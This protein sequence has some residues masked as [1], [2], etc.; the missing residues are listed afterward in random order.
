MKINESYVD[1][2]LFTRETLRAKRQ[3]A[4]EAALLRIMQCSPESTGLL[5]FEQSQ[6][7]LRH[8]QR[9]IVETSK[10]LKLPHKVLSAALVF[11]KRFF[12]AKSIYDEDPR[13]IRSFGGVAEDT[14]LILFSVACLWVATKSEEGDHYIMT[15]DEWAKFGDF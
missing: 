2:W 14:L 13:Q 9:W 15:S 7:L 12:A 6:M 5:V 8:H 1:T 4:H 3:G 11:F 10:R